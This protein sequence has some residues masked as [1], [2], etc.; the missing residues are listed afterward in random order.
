MTITTG[1]YCGNTSIRITY[2]GV[3]GLLSTTVNVG[4]KI[5]EEVTKP[6]RVGGVAARYEVY[7]NLHHGHGVGDGNKY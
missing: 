5:V 1:F 4:S 2:S 7:S 6:R 3:S